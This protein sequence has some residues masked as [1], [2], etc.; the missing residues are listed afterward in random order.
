M[1]NGPIAF[2]SLWS[3]A[4]IGLI[5]FIVILLVS[6]YFAMGEDTYGTVRQKGSSR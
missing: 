3:T 4:E 2:D 5:A 6:V 1:L